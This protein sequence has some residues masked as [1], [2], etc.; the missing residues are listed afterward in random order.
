MNLQF[1]EL[2]PYGRNA[3]LLLKRPPLNI[4]NQAMCEELSHFL[5]M[6]FPIKEFD[7]LVLASEGEYFCAGADIGE[8]FPEKVGKMLPVFN[9]L[10]RTVAEFPLPTVAIVSG[11]CL[12][13]GA[14]L[15]RA[16]RKVIAL[17]PKTLYFGVPEIKLACYPPFGLAVFPRLS[18]DITSTIRFLLTG[19]ILKGEEPWQLEDMR[20]MGLIDETFTGTLENLIEQLD[21]RSVAE[22]PKISSL[23]GE[24]LHIDET[25]V[26]QALADVQ[27]HTAKLSSFVLNQAT[28]VLTHCA[29]NAKTLTEALEFS[30][31]VYLQELAPHP[32]Y[33][34]GLTAF[35]K[36]REPVYQRTG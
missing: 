20:V 22:L 21:F 9:N 35:K 18:K 1:T 14:E 32:D 33:A 36:K 5:L 30:E 12:G 8:H 10:C 17:N 28:S 34:E 7:L 19:K 25:T 27:Q 23:F 24:V 15:V 16:C 4:L 3:V 29:Q 11:K 31:T 6:E 2:K 13:G 26:A